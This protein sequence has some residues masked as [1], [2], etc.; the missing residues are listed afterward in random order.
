MLEKLICAA[1]MKA[2]KSLVLFGNITIL[3]AAAA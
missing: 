1:K 3:A 2:Y